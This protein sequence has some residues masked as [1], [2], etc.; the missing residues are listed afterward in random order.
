MADQGISKSS[1]KLVPKDPSSSMSIRD[2]DSAITTFST[3]F[4]RFGLVKVGGRATL[5]KLKTGNLA[6]FSPVALTPEVKA[7]VAER[8]SAAP[9]GE[10]KYLIAPDVEHHIFLSPWAKEYTNADVIGMQGLPEKREKDESTRGLKFHHVFTPTN[11]R[12]LRITPEFDDEFDYEFIDA[13]RNKELVFF[14][15]PTRTLIEADLLFNLPATEQFSR[16]GEGATSGILSRFFA[17]IMHTKGNMIWQRRLLW[18]G[19]GSSNRKAFA[20]SVRK[21]R[22]WGAFDRIV[23]CHGDVIE[24]GGS[25]ILAKATAWYIDGKH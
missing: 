6:V 12:D 1:Q 23:P 10:V 22:S 24:R 15:K 25:E 4:L 2:L 17:S 14:H 9:A 5:V 18:Y 3:P 8:A 21:M 7:K 16:S 19:P 20:D 11:K 13:H